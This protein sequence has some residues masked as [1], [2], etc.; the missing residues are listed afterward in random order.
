MTGLRA[1]DFANGQTRRANGGVQFAYRALSMAANYSW[2]GVRRGATSGLAP[3]AFV[4][5]RPRGL[6]NVSADYVVPSRH[7]GLRDREQPPPR[8]ARKRNLRPRYPAYARV[9]S[10]RRDGAQVQIGLKGTF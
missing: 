1:G 6:V 4:F 2:T 7:D 5:T 9:S 8:S 3:N 10:D